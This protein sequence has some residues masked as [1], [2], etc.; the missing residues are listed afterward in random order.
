MANT[1]GTPRP[2]RQRTL[3][4]WQKIA[5]AALTRIRRRFLSPAPPVCTTEG[6]EVIRALAGWV[7]PGRGGEH[8]ATEGDAMTDRSDEFV[9][10]TEPCR[11]GLLAHCYRMLG[12]TD[13][14]EDVVQETY[15]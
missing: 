2:Q 8:G 6:D 15:L 13:E 3:P 14:A 11:R 5:L 7:R 9:R 4:L 1:L 10:S 12:S